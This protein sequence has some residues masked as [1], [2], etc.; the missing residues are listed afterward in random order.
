MRHSFGYFFYLEGEFFNEDE[1]LWV[2][3]DKA[4][5]LPLLKDLI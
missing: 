2:K 4:I 5:F 3:L 1:G